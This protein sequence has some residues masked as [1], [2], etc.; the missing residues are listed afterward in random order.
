MFS[1]QQFDKAYH[2]AVSNFPVTVYLDRLH[3]E[4]DVTWSNPH[5]T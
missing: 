1:Q 5:P 3:W 2:S 4:E